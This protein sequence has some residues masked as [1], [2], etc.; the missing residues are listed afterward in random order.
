MGVLDG[1]ETS[2]GRIAKNV[3]RDDTRVTKEQSLAICAKV[4]A[5]TQNLVE[6]QVILVSNAQIMETTSP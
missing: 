2:P 6:L 5:S 1:M 4:G 3:F